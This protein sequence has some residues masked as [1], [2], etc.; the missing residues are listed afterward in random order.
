MPRRLQNDA[1]E[2]LALTSLLTPLLAGRK[3]AKAAGRQMACLT[4]AFAM[5]RT[6]SQEWSLLSRAC[7]QEHLRGKF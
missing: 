6:R 3:A 5:C 1:E 7:L 4:L 2:L